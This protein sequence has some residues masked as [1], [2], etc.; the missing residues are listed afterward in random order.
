[1]GKMRLFI[2]KYQIFLFF[3][4]STLLGYWPWYIYG[5]PGWFMYGMPLTGVVLVGITQGKKGIK[6]QLKSAVRIKAKPRH[7]LEILG[8]LISVCLLTLL[9]SYLLFGDVPTFKMIRKEPHLIPLL[10]LAILFGGPILEEVFGL[11]GYV[12][13]VLL[14]TKSPFISS[15]IVGAYFGAWHLVEFYR[16]GSSQYAIGLKYYPLFIITEISFSIIMTWYYIKSNKNLFLAGVFF[17]WM[18]NNSSVIFLTDIT[19]T[20]MESA[21][22]MNP[23]Y[24]LVQSVIIS[25]LAVVFVVKGKMHINLEALR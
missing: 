1:M 9:I 13:P 2:E 11:R 20:G 4:F 18:M 7:Y 14:R 3:L 22:K 25:L 17:H 5:E 19:L 15:I 23:H 16:P 8:I 6:E 10:F 24:F 21:P 12:L